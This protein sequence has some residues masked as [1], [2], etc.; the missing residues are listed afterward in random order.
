MMLPLSWPLCLL[1]S[2]TLPW[3]TCRL[4]GVDALHLVHLSSLY[5][6]LFSPLLLLFVV[7]VALL[8]LFSLCCCFLLSF[9]V[10]SSVIVLSHSTFCSSPDV[11]I[12]HS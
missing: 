8:L 10:D 1:T 5:D 9:L 2:L 7:V 4:D 11:Y 3:L 6:Y 12:H